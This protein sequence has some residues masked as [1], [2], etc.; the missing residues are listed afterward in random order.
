MVNIRVTKIKD[1]PIQYLIELDN[2]YTK[3]KDIKRNEAYYNVS[4]KGNVL[5]KKTAGYSFLRVAD[6][7]DEL[8]DAYECLTSDYQRKLN[9]SSTDLDHD[10]YIS[11]VD[12]LVKSDFIKESVLDNEAIR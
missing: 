8:L 7:L 5:Y 10:S 11:L 3:I 1:K 12:Y 6:V 9:I 4:I 2:N